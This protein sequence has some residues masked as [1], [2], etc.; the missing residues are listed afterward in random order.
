M[1]AVYYLRVGPLLFL[2]L[3]L[4]SCEQ[5]VQQVPVPIALAGL[6]GRWQQDS[7]AI[8]FYNPQREFG[9]RVT[10][11]FER[12]GVLVLT[13][14]CWYYVG[15]AERAYTRLGGALYLQQEAV[16]LEN[17]R[18]DTLVIITLDKHRV[19]SRDSTKEANGGFRV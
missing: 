7:A 4:L 13:P 14:T 18:V 3:L 16:G 12:K 5:R 1:S 10:Y 6:E 8:I 2:P 19:I 11:P 15:E 9:H 17:G